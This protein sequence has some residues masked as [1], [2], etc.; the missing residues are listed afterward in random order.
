[1]DCDEITGG[2][3]DRVST[4][5]MANQ[6]LSKP[7]VTNQTTSQATT[8]ASVPGSSAH[9][10]RHCA[11]VRDEGW[12]DEEEEADQEADQVD[13]TSTCS[14]TPTYGTTY[15]PCVTPLEVNPLGLLGTQSESAIS[16]HEI[17]KGERLFYGAHMGS[18][19]RNVEF[20]RGGGEYLR[21]SFRAHLRRYA[22]AFLNSGGGSLLAGVDDDGVV[23]GLR[24][25]HRQED[26]AR[27]LVDSILKGFH[28]TLLPHSYTLTFLPVVRPGPES[29]NL[30]VLRLTLRPPPA[31]TQQG[32]YQTDQGEVFLRRDG[33]VEGPLSASAIQEWARQVCRY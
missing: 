33:S 23:R 24:C 14:Q 26:Q 29:Q 30:K 28:P 10:G 15:D 21:S 16:R 19:T 20:K 32:L 3:W 12:E 9:I 13:S 31:L 22:C 17:T 27:L 18:E 7:R 1:M 6:Q 8:T 25:D 5:A 2:V 4:P 11:R